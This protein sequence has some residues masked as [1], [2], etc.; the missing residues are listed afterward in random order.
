MVDDRSASNDLQRQA[1]L[2]VSDLWRFYDEHAAQARQ[3]ETLRSSVTA[4]LSGVAAAVV[5]FAG[6]N[7]I[8]R[9]DLLPGATVILLGVLG[10]AL[11]IKHYERNQFHVAVLSETRKDID[12]A[13]A[14]TTFKPRLTR[15]IR[16][17]AKEVHARKFT[18][19]L[20]LRTKAETNVPVDGQS[21]WVS[22]PLHL[23]WL[24]LPA[25]VAVIGVIVCVLALMA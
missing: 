20:G 19:R 22:V 2:T 1:E 13:R 8:E 24:L 17:E 21:P 10:I 14:Q 16:K 9:A 25:L 7:G 4:T 15:A 12:S 3:H 18:L 5:G 6:V 23:L 11:S